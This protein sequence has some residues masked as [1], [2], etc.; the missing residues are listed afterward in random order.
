MKK[1]F[2]WMAMGGVLGLIAAQAPDLDAGSWAGQLSAPSF[3]ELAKKVQPAVVNISTTKVIKRR[4]PQM[5]PF[6][7]GPQDPFE[8]FFNKYFEGV[9]REQRRNSLGSGFI[10]NKD[11]HILTNNHVVEGADEVLVTLA[12]GRKFKAAV[13]GTDPQSD[14][15]VLKIKAGGDVPFLALGDS[16]KA[17]PGE[18]V[19]AIGNPF[20]FSHTVTVGVISAKGRLVEGENSYGK[21]LQTD[22]SINP[23][24][25]GGPLFNGQGEVIGINSMIYGMGTGIGFAIPIN[26]AKQMVP[27]LIAKGSVTRGW[28]GVAI[29]RVTPELAKSF[30]LD[31]EKGALIADVYPGSP[32]DKG[33]LKRGDIVTQFGDKP[34]EE[35]YDLTLFVAQTP[36]GKP[37]ELTV[38][39]AGKEMKLTVSVA[40]REEEKV[41]ARAPG[42]PSEEAKSDA[43]GLVVRS[44]RLDEQRESGLTEGVVIQRVEP[45]SSAEMSDVREGDL[46]LEI[47]GKPIKT[48]EDYQQAGATLKKGEVARLLLR[49]GTATI[50]VAFTI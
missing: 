4:V 45:E 6:G 44:L 11:G 12:D 21:F 22:A 38:L 47:N 14:L 7:G 34:I 32:A 31:N 1:K 48:V 50:H 42:A 5:S 39:R 20:G 29:Q 49:R 30:K 37:S 18:W 3:A 23:G 24:N 2:L 27:Q 40:K 28:L 15:A 41:S 33:G 46:L 13:A 36:V 9:P 10:I 8:D 43:L 16:D 17:E 26:L 35:P 25:S 19:M